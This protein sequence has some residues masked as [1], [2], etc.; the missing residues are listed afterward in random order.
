M[1]CWQNRWAVTRQSGFLINAQNRSAGSTGVMV[2]SSQPSATYCG[3]KE[4]NLAV[5][6]NRTA[7][8]AA[9][10]SQGQQPEMAT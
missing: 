7:Q 2:D 4:R 9:P 1:K 6:R 8:N 3:T 10:S 5:L